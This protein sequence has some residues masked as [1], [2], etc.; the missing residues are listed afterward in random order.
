M[1]P[2][3]FDLGIFF[4]VNWAEANILAFKEL[5]LNVKHVTS[6]HDKKTKRP[7]ALPMTT[8]ESKRPRASAPWPLIT[9]R[10]N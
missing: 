4:M 8:Y 7:Q 5:G 10:V 2:F 9:L 6:R 1:R 3:G